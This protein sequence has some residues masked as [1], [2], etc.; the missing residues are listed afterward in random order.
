MAYP[1]EVSVLSGYREGSGNEGRLPVR[2]V[3]TTSHNTELYR[4]TGLQVSLQALQV[5]GVGDGL[6]IDGDDHVASLKEDVLG[7][8]AG[9]D[10]NY[11][12]AVLLEAHALL[13]LAGEV[14]HLHTEAD[15]SAFLVLVRS[16]AIL[17]VG[18]GEDLRQVPN[19][20]L[21]VVLAGV[22]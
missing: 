7:E 2:V 6:T 12:N 3:A 8:R 14:L 4:I 18:F 20:D 16:N 10:A 17:A 22:A 19:N 13:H 11:L 9:F 21:I 1:T 5:V 15:I